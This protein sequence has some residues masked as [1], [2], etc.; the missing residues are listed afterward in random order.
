MTP[1][2][3]GPLDGLLVADFSRVVAGPYATMLLG[4]L[5]AEVIKVERPEGGDDTRGFGPPFVG[6]Q[7]S[8]YLS[9]NRN[10]RGVAWDLSTE[11]GRRK[12]FQLAVRADV[13]VENFRPGTAAKFG[14]GYQDVAAANAKVVYCSVSGFGTSGEGAKLPGYDFLVQGVGGLMSITGDPGGE[15]RKVGV[16]VVDVLTAQFATSAIL[17]ALYERQQSGRGQRVEV[18][19]LSSLLSALI[20]QAST[21]V[22]TGAVPKAMGNDHPS[23]SPY[24]T[25]HT[26]D[27]LL[28]IAVGNDPQFRGLAEA[29]GL[30]WMADDDRFATNA[31]R[32]SNRAVLV[33]LLE[34]RLRTR[35][36]SD[37]L[38]S[39]QAAGIP[40]G[41]VNDIGEAFALAHRLGL[42]PV[43]NLDRAG[44]VSP[45]SPDAP[46]GEA[47]V[48]SP[49]GFSQTPATYRYAPP[50]LGEHTSEVERELGIA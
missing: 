20:N 2:K 12:A 19:L 39:I 11:E 30:G 40:G 28:V 32:V 46:A 33:E 36:A 49:M 10:K 7:S 41:T 43:L 6:G 37:W 1:P 42:E 22:T 48:R 13:V 47:Q 38:G 34:G 5:G 23:I 4:D 29:I 9:I 21:Y 17:A 3:K 8:Y 50:L 25:F 14:L 31:A 35:P 45:R 24:E 18:N 27:R 16:A 44:R 15:P 26:A